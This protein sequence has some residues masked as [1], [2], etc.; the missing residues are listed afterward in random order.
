VSHGIVLCQEPVVKVPERSG[1]QAECL[2]HDAESMSCRS[3]WHGLQ[4][5]QDFH[6]GLLAISAMSW[7]RDMPA[8][9]PSS[10]ST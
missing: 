8:P 2:C 9:L 7:L 10:K 5:V 1:A 6:H 4:S 3:P